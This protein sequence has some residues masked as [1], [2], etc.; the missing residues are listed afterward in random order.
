MQTLI[1]HWQWIALGVGVLGVLIPAYFKL[2]EK[3]GWNIL[4]KEQHE[5]IL[6]FLKNV[7]DGIFKLIK[8]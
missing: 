3:T 8:K 2:S 1:E 4:S 7:K 5:A 6:E